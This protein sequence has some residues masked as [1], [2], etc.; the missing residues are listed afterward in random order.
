M[1]KIFKYPLLVQGVQELELPYG[2]QILTVQAQN[3]RTV[4]GPIPMLW[5]KVPS[6][7]GER[8]TRIIRTVATGQEIEEDD[9]VYLG[10]YQLEDGAFIAHVFEVL[11]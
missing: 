10:T 5:A 1:E 3:T 8:Q 9:M 7:V 6:D 2:A 11:S 4:A